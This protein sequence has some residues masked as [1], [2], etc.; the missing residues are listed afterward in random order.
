M[1]T[2]GPP[3]GGSAHE[4]LPLRDATVAVYGPAERPTGNLP[5]RSPTADRLLM[6]FKRRPAGL[7]LVAL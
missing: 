7:T 2:M 3:R 5:S 4:C 1:V 6:W